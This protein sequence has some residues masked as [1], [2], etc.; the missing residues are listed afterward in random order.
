VVICPQDIAVTNLASVPARPGSLNEFLLSG[1]NAFDSCENNLV[2]VCTDAPT[3]TGPCSS[4]IERTHTVTDSC[5]NSVSCVQVIT[6]LKSSSGISARDDSVRATKD[7]PCLFPKA[8]LLSNDTS[9]DGSPLSMIEVS[10]SSLKGGS[11]SLSGTNILYNP[12]AGLADVD[13]F[14][15]TV[16]D[17]CGNTATA[18][19]TVTVVPANQSP[20]VASTTVHTALN[21]PATLTL[22]NLLALAVDP[23]GDALTLTSAQIVGNVGSVTLTESNVIAYPPLNFVGSFQYTF[24]VSDG[25]DG[26]GIGTV[27]VVVEDAP[28]AMTEGTPAFNPQTG[29]F[30]QRVTATNG[31]AT[32]IA[33]LQF[34]ISG[35]P[36]NIR[37]WNASGTNAGTPYVQYNHP[38]DPGQSVT[39]RIEYYVPDRH[40]FTPVITMK[41]VT[42]AGVTDVSSAGTVA[43]DRCFMDTR[44]ADEPRFVIEFTSIPGRVYTILYSDDGM[45]WAPATPSVTATSNRT[46]WYDDGPPKTETKP[47]TKGIRLYRV[48]LAP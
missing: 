16:R 27:T 29:L 31:G 26:F 12:P 23:D 30:E 1:G 24:T 11:V 4:T 22:S 40:P 38:V 13:V 41:N 10:G 34:C 42:P 47:T 36:S 43:I 46:Q 33:A 19:V 7:V 9:A 6:V 14:T 39:V 48:L 17:E 2:Y 5:F 37:V 15:Y 8:T 44:L 21:T 32:T 20:V 18:T 28:L 3:I 35:L 45:N 25:R